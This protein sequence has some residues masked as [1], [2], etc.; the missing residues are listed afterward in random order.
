VV[1]V[2]VKG[3]GRAVVELPASYFGMLGDVVLL[4]P[5]EEVPFVGVM[6]RDDL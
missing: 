1:V 5:V 2:L 4:L 6:R 3:G